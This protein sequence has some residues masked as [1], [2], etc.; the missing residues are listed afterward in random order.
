MLYFIT[1]A[2]GTAVAAPALE[3]LGW[4]GTSITALAAL[5]LAAHLGRTATRHGHRAM[6]TEGRRAA[7]SQK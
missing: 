4:H 6:V 1:G 3:A 2:I 5:L 7:C